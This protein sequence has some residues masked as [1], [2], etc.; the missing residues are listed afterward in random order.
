MKSILVPVGNTQNGVNNLR[1]A[2]NFAI[3][4]GAK[5]YLINIY[6]E[7]SKAGGLTKVTNLAIQDNQKQL[8]E[9]MAQVDTQG[10]EV[11][12]SPIKGDPYD[13]IARVSKQV[14]VDLIIMSPQS[15]DI[16]DE[17]YLGNITGKLVKQTD[18]PMLIVP[19]N[20]LFRKAESI[21]LA[22]KTATFEDHKV[23]DPMIELGRLFSAT[24]NV[25]RV[26]TPDVA[27]Q[28]QSVDPALKAVM[29]SYTETKNATIYQGVL[30][31]FQSV[32]PDILCVLRRKRGFF[33]K[34]MESNAVYKKDFYT[35][36][37]LL[38]LCGEQ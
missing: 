7:F 5:V 8:E 3:M 2:V 32:K 21:L 31:H 4:S 20:Y 24:I 10:V 34:L 38:I 30:E 11:I 6:K 35:S 19:P 18:I 37:P 13:G 16:K 29:A 26:E 25:L 9:V 22:V 28:N 1:Y 14:G 12:A 15:V 23:L 27:G 17:V 36:I 33:Q